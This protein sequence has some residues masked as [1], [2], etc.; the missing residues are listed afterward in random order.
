MRKIESKIGLMQ[1]AIVL[2]FVPPAEGQNAV[3]SLAANGD[4]L[5]TAEMG[6]TQQPFDEWAFEP[7][8]NE[9]DPEGDFY[10]WVYFDIFNGAYEN[11]Y[12]WE[13]VD[14]TT[15]RNTW[16]NFTKTDPLWDD[17]LKHAYYFGL[18]IFGS[19]E[20]GNPSATN[21]TGI[22]SLRYNGSNSYV[23]GK[24]NQG[25][26]DAWNGTLSLSLSIPFSPTGEAPIGGT[27]DQGSNTTRT[28]AVRHD[29]ESGTDT[30]QWIGGSYGTADYVSDGLVS[31]SYEFVSYI[32]THNDKL[33]GPHENFLSAWQ[34]NVPYVRF[35]IVD[36][37]SPIPPATS[38]SHSTTYIGESNIN[39]DNSF[40]IE[41]PAHVKFIVRNNTI[42]FSKNFTA[43]LGSSFRT[44]NDG[45]STS[46]SKGNSAPPPPSIEVDGSELVDDVVAHSGLSVHPNPSNGEIRISYRVDIAGSVLIGVYDALGRR[47]STLVDRAHQQEGDH[48]YTWNLRNT[49]PALNS[50]TYIVRVI[51]GGQVRSRPFVFIN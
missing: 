24:F 27:L 28:D 37:S 46:L 41:S 38:I 22:D 8:G 39:I 34:P 21:N 51:Q 13:N 15:F 6:Y 26:N 2:F 20:F 49:T 25:I 17:F 5:V 19:D 42:K 48:Q 23:A 1:A 14:E 50:G 16:P 33:E 47:V 10:N 12:T 36:S 11:N 3:V 30:G 9:A 40:T 44:Y 32:N 7:Y 31:G 4:L 29:P 43:E 45:G 18:Y 35:T